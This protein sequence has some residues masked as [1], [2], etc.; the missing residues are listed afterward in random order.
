MVCPDTDSAVHTMPAIIMTKNMPVGP[1]RPNCNSTTDDTM[2]VSMVMPETGLRAVVA[3]Q[4]AAT[5]VKKNEKKTTRIS[6]ATT[7][8]GDVPRVANMMATPIAL[9]TTPIRIAITEMSRSVRSSAAP[10]P[11]R[12]AFIATPNEPATTRSDFTMAKMPAVAMAPT[13]TKRT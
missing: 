11:P 4:S 1:E 5:D 12:N 8:A 13:P 7:T 2:M 10:S 3:M 6:P 9:T